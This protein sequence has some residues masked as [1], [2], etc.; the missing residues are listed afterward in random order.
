[1][2]LKEVLCFSLVESEGLEPSSWNHAL[3]KSSN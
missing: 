3:V 2:S 1:M